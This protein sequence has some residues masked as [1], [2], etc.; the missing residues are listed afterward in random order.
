MGH[1]HHRFP[2]TQLRVV[3][4]KARPNNNNNNNN[5]KTT[6]VGSQNL[7]CSW[8]SPP[9]L[10]LPAEPV[11]AGT[12]ESGSATATDGRVRRFEV[13]RPATSIRTLMT[14]SGYLAPQFGHS[15]GLQAPISIGLQAPISIQ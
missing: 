12:G 7:F 6:A 5:N 10:L 13:A 15:I 14:T 4:A 3:G 9:T 2:R 1:H 8:P 11:A